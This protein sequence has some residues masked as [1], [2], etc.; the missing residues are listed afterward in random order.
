MGSNA[1]TRCSAYGSFARND[2]RND[3][4]KFL[5]RRASD[6]PPPKERWSTNV[7]QWS[8]DD[9]ARRRCRAVSATLGVT[10][11]LGH[12]DEL[13]P[14]SQATKPWSTM[15]LRGQHVGEGPHC[16]VHI[17]A[18]KHEIC[19]VLLGLECLGRLLGL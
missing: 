17:S 19:A 13:L 8:R 4:K 7:P 16:L 2:T 10:M 14:G 11:I 12:N 5:R 9:G 6:R 3:A 18:A 15:A 1:T